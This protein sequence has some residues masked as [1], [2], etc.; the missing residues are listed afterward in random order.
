MTRRQLRKAILA[1]ALIAAGNGC[2]AAQESASSQE[3]RY[4]A[5]FGAGNW[6]DFVVE[7]ARG[8]GRRPLALRR[9]ALARGQPAS[10]NAAFG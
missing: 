7:R 3:A 1:L 8:D 6:L 2:A 5:H 9:S 4:G 10:A